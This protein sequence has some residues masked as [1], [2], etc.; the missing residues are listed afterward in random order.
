MR[1]FVAL[2]YRKYISDILQAV[3]HICIYIKRFVFAC[4]RLFRSVEAGIHF[5]HQMPSTLRRCGWISPAAAGYRSGS[6]WIHVFIIQI[7]HSATERW[8]KLI[9][10]ALANTLTS[11]L[12]GTSV[13]YE[14]TAREWIAL[15]LLCNG[16]RASVIKGF[17]T[18]GWLNVV[19]EIGFTNEFYFNIVDSFIFLGVLVILWLT[20]G[21]KAYAFDTF[22]VRF[23]RR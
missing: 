13:W 2:L 6:L 23:Q 4:W 7:W 11:T 10:I 17:L 20:R 9:C 1:E 21:K 19:S 14:T 3:V 15:F 12:S 16:I 18:L 22:V 8:F 5:S